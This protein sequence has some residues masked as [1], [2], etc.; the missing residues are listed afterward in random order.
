MQ[1]RAGDSLGELSETIGSVFLPI[2]DAV[3]PALIPIVTAL[4]TLV[5][6][7]LPILIPLVKTL[8]TVLGIV[9]TALSIVVGWL[10]KLI[11]FLVTAIGKVGDFLS[12]INPLKDFKLPSLPF[13]SASS[14]SAA[15]TGVG[16]SAGR[17]AAP[18]APAPASITI[19]TTGDGIE[20]EQAVV[21]ALRRV[22]RLNGGVI[23]AAP[24]WSTS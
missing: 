23:P 6:A 20:A 14:S 12:K 5:K 24:G 3:I 17:A 15:P 13:L 22:T 8:A 4:G 1:A 9:A 10:A 18:A 16:R 7:V 11:D 21:R 2:L 19:Y